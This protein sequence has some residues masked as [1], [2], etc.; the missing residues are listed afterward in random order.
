MKRAIYISLLLC[1][2][3][4]STALVAMLEADETGV[5]ELL[6][7]VRPISRQNVGVNVDFHDEVTSDQ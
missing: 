4:A 2:V 6:V 1:A 5:T 3:L 7:Q